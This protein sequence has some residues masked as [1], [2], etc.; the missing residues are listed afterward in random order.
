MKRQS[1][2]AAL[3]KTTPEINI[4]Q[5]YLEVQRLRLLVQQAETLRVRQVAAKPR[6]SRINR[7]R[8]YSA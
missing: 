2:F 7:E 5:A 6:G 8:R 4:A 1:S 3:S